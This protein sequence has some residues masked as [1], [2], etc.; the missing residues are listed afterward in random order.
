MKKYSDRVFK[1]IKEKPILELLTCVAL[2]F[3]TLIIYNQ[4]G[5]TK[6]QAAAAKFEQAEKAR[7]RLNTIIDIKGDFSQIA[8]IFKFNFEGDMY[9]SRSCS[10][11]RLE[12]LYRF[13]KD[14]S[15]LNVDEFTFYEDAMRLSRNSIKGASEL[16]LIYVAFHLKLLGVLNQNQASFISM[17]SELKNLIK[18][19]KIECRLDVDTFDKLNVY[20]AKIDP[21]IRNLDS[22]TSITLDGL[23]KEIIFSYYVRNIN[24]NFETADRFASLTLQDFRDSI[25]SVALEFSSLSVSVVEKCDRQVL[26]YES[27]LRKFD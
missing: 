22:Y 16:Y 20:A 17:P 15:F 12:A 2:I 24:N 21:W 14:E 6:D 1:V 23:M 25:H 3:Q 8:Q 11:I 26:K 27:E 4:M 5:P 13:L 10:N 19:A 9:C 7:D 18:K